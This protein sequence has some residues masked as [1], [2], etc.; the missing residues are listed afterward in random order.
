MKPALVQI[1][2]LVAQGPI[3]WCFRASVADTDAG[4][5][6][7]SGTGQ[8]GPGL[9]EA[10]IELGGFVQGMFPLE[11]VPVANPC[12]D[13]AEQAG[14]VKAGLEAADLEMAGVVKLTE[15]DPLP[16]RALAT[17]QGYNSFPVDWGFTAFA[18]SFCVSAEIIRQRLMILA[19]ISDCDNSPW[20]A[21]LNLAC[22]ACQFPAN[23]FWRNRAVPGLPWDQ[24]PQ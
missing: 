8:E 3:L 4:F 12:A 7:A 16:Y 23:A 13:E 20:S 5:N 6:R 24:S 21:W 1:G 15:Q 9:I 19:W 2:M 11:I 10:L 14:A 17:S 18:G 22:S